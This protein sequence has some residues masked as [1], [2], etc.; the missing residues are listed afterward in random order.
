M[1]ACGGVRGEGDGGVGDGA[2]QAA[3]ELVVGDQ[4]VVVGGE[5]GGELLEE[6]LEGGGEAGDRAAGLEPQGSCPRRW[7]RGAG[8]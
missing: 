6:G 8:A 5:G 1:S 7:G 2:D 4:G 3:A